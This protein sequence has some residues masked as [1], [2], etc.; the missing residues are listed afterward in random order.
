MADNKYLRPNFCKVLNNMTLRFITYFHSEAE[1]RFEKEYYIEEAKK[2]FEE[3]PELKTLKR[4]LAYYL[5]VMHLP[6]YSSGNVFSWTHFPGENPIIACVDMSFSEFCALRDRKTKGIS[7]EEYVGCQL[8]LAFLNIKNYEPMLKTII[9]AYM[10]EPCKSKPYVS[11]SKP[12]CAG[13]G[14][15]CSDVWALP[16]SKYVNYL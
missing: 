13:C 16:R 1:D 10:G 3:Y 11:N 6:P 5:L 9:Y 12:I 8:D 4:P 2:V 7:V 15:D 14:F